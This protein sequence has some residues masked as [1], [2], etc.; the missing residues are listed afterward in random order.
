M[1]KPLKRHE[2]LKPLSR[3]HHQILLLCWKIREGFKKDISAERIKA[4][5]SFFYETQLVPHFAFEEKEVFPLLHE[6][7]PLRKQ[8]LNEHQ[9]LI[10]LFTE[11]Y[12]PEKALKEI[13]Q[14]LEDHI[15]FEERVLFE[16]IQ[17]NNTE[18]ELAQIS[19]KEVAP[20]TPDPDE[21]E[22]QFWQK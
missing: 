17:N 18:G 12:E 10:A 9:R 15:R 19:K 22:D 13:E 4:Y 1:T 5:A 20:D 8:A 21:W 2:S 3:E 11:D 14:A 7:N 6:H 16:E